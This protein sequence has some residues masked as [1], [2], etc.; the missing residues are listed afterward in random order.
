[1][2][3]DW[4]RGDFRRGHSSHNGRAGRALRWT[5]QTQAGRGGRLME[6]E[7]TSDRQK[8]NARQS[9]ASKQPLSTPP[10]HT[11]RAGAT[12]EKGGVDLVEVGEKKD[13]I[14][15]ER[16]SKRHG[17]PGDTGHLVA[18][19]LAGGLSSWL[20]WMTTRRRGGWA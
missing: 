17:A 5:G 6:L 7:V 20:G 14:G 11:G 12:G 18:C 1:V 9:H 8:Q 16:R 19:P 4:E 15:L 10:R 3:F 2:G 13:A